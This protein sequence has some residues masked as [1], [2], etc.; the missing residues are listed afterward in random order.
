MIF[1]FSCLFFLNLNFFAQ[2]EDQAKRKIK[3]LKGLIEKAEGNNIDATK[4]KMAIRT[5]EIFLRYAKW[6]KKNTEI[7][8]E[9]YKHVP[10]YKKDA[11]DWA[12][13]LPKFEVAEVNLLL[14]KSIDVISSEINGE[15]KRKPTQQIDWSKLKIEGNKVINTT[16]NLPVY[17]ADWIWKPNVDELTE[18][19]GNMDGFF[20]T[21]GHL[22][23]GKLKP[24]VKNQ[25]INKESGQ[26][27]SV[28]L[29][30]TSVPK[31]AKDKYEGIDTMG[32]RY[33]AYDIDHP[34]ARALNETLLSQTVPYIKDK[35]YGTLYMMTNEPHWHTSEKAWNTGGVSE[36][37]FKKFR[38]WLTKEHESIG[39]LNKRWK[40]NFKSF[41]NVILPIPITENLKGTPQWY[42]WIRFNQIRVNEW[43]TFLD[44][45]IKKYAPNTKTHIKIMTNL[46]SENKRNNGIDLEALSSL[47]DVLGNDAGSHYSRMWGKDK[48]NWA[49]YYNFNWN[50]GI[51]ATCPLFPD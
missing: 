22:E 17:L 2:S 23:K 16:T 43:F 6:D 41:D 39:V 42:D 26:L 11:A 30:H 51:W 25:L 47:T 48:S 49:D 35:K 13:K 15:I 40:S 10:I 29:N 28:F 44:G 37:T 32:R 24:F 14:D 31:W 9:F 7:N 4:E 50:E 34:G 1:V 36:Y 20:F 18:Y 19:Y 45:T 21:H 8:E 27:G 46:W 12:K 5:A 33:T 38:N 3:K